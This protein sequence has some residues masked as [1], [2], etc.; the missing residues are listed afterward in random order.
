[1]SYVFYCYLCHDFFLVRE[2]SSAVM[3]NGVRIC[4]LGSL[5]RWK[6]SSRIRKSTVPNFDLL[7]KK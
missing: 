3:T 6:S 1:M 7:Y 4:W 5:Q 2:H